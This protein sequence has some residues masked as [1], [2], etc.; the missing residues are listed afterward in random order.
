MKSAKRGNM[1]VGSLG[2]RS[3]MDL[4]SL[5]KGMVSAQK[6]AKVK[7]Y[8][9]KIDKYET[10]LSAF[11]TVTS[12]IDSFK[13]SVQK[14]NNETLF[15]G[16]NAK[17][18]QEEGKEALSVKA[19]TNSANGSYSINV[20]QVAK[21]SRIMSSVGVFKSADDQITGNGGA[22]TISAGN[23][24]FSIDI[25]PNTTL[26]QLRSQINR[27]TDNFGVSANILDDGQGNVFFSVTS[28]KSGD[29]NT[30]QISNR[31]PPPPEEDPLADVLLEDDKKEPLPAASKDGLTLDSVS[32]IGMAPGMYVPADGEAKDAIIT[33][34]GIKVENEDNA[35]D[36]AVS[37]LSIEAMDVTDKP[38]EVTVSYDLDTVKQTVQDFVTSYNDLHSM[39]EKSSAKGSVL[40]G[41]SM[42]RN[43][44]SSMSSKLME[45][46]SD[47]G[48]FTSVFDVGLKL[49]KD[50][51]LSLDDAKFQD[52]MKKGYSDVAGLFTGSG[53]LAASMESMLDNYTGSRG[54][55]S[56]FK[57]S[58][59]H[60]IDQS[61]ES[62]ESYQKR[63]DRYED[64]LRSKFSNLD[65]RLGEMKSQG[66]RLNSVLEK[67]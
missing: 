44:K 17:I 60:S 51:S 20:D 57:D 63:M 8:K 6:D 9:D 25:D 55:S 10:E 29:G 45:T 31:P 23:E 16:R 11:G 54:M 42:V 19:N 27:A 38:K 22:L 28:T 53:G 59:Q 52:A 4:E 7:L 26:A 32:T 1:A 12:S 58:I 36:K 67:M 49:N 41:N 39:L 66:E 2:S 15:N 35:F 65:N 18:D 14:L 37:G 46:H 50:G 40:N 34:D 3:G 21:G 43:L 64:T 56:T 33:V 30:I 48:V 24:S 61:E 13:S 47:T 5:V 62:L